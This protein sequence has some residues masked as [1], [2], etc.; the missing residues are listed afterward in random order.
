MPAPAIPDVFKPIQRAIIYIRV[1]TEREE[2][3][4][5][6][7]QRYSC[8]Q[9][10]LRNGIKIIGEPVEDLDLSGTSSSKRQISAII[11]RVRA[12][13][14]NVVLVWKWSRFGRNIR[15]SQVNLHELEKAGG[16]LIA[17]T[18]DYD[19]DTYHGRFSRDNMLLVADLQAGIIGA[20]WKEAHDRR[21]RA[22]LPHT[23]QARFGYTRCPDCRRKEDAPDEYHRCNSCEGVLVIDPVR[24]QALAEAYE[25]YVAGAS[26]AAIARDMKDRGIR[27]LSGTVMKPTAWQLV[28]DSGFAAGLI[29]WRGPEFRR[30]HG[31][32]S[33]RPET[34]DNWAVGK[35]EP[36]I[37][38]DLWEAYKRRRQKSS[39]IPWS[40]EAKYAYSGLL[41]C[42]APSADGGVC[43]RRMVAS[44]LIRK[45]GTEMKLFRCSGI[46]MKECPG[47]TITLKRL[48]K[49]VTEWLD[50]F[51]R[52]AD[53]GVMA[54]KRAA[55]RAQA[56]SDIPAARAEISV[57]QTRKKKLLDLY[58]KDLVSEKDYEEKAAEL[59]DEL[60]TL[61]NRLAAL[62]VDAG[63]GV[64]PTADDFGELLTIWPR[65]TPDERRAALSQVISRIEIIKTPGYKHN[66][67]DIIPK[68][69]SP[70]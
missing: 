40:T 1:S 59:D 9:Y 32:A 64:V 51:A 63:Q 69:E 11:E 13:E 37:S 30:L 5:P 2:M 49:A 55:R 53:M 61:Q 17:V 36:L 60:A 43:G 15:E 10:A 33:K 20:T 65:M 46:A 12:G 14:A 4:S 67:I 18:E 62:E 26:M 3:Q 58:L 19:T 28:M 39:T 7:Q 50:H 56:D 16:R 70:V 47:V 6:E 41:I 35:H 31:R 23:G 24:G 21:H 48:D 42:G 52:G 34:Y 8:E 27:S 44:A 25:R 54:M 68:W 66:R 22:G 57:V 45:N 38:M 29:R